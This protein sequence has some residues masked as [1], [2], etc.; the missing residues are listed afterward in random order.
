V[1]KELFLFVQFFLLGAGL[2]LCYDCLRVIRRIFGHGILWISVEDFVFGMAAGGWFFL[3]LCQWN[4]G[5]VR[6]YLL[7]AVLLG[8]VTYYACCGRHLMKFFEKIIIFVKKQL[9]K[10]GEAATMR[11]EKFWRARTH[12]E[13]K[14]KT[15]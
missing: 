12:E 15:P 14:K 4:D 10:L 6:G 2:V 9:K 11:V 3:R 5:I 7:L 8:A 1:K 13:T